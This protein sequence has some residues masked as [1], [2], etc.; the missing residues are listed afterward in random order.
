MTGAGI[1][2]R[3]IGGTATTDEVTDAIVAALQK[4][5]QPA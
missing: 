4:A 2:T 5:L 1:K 3:D